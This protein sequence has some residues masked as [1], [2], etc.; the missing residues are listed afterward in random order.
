MIY[1]YI[2]PAT[3]ILYILINFQ[4]LKNNILK[5]LKKKEYL[6]KEELFRK[7]SKENGQFHSKLA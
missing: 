2:P 6:L 1:T 5:R 7:N 4:K 3:A